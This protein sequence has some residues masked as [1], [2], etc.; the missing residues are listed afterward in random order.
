MKSS[1]FHHFERLLV[2]AALAAGVGYFVKS[3]Q[4][5]DP[6]VAVAVNPGA[7]EKVAGRDPAKPKA[8][9]KKP[10]SKKAQAKPSRERT[11]SREGDLDDGVPWL[12][13]AEMPTPTPKHEDSLAK[14]PEPDVAKAP[15]VQM[16]EQA[17]D[18]KFISIHRAMHRNPK[19]PQPLTDDIKA[20]LDAID[21]P[22]AIRSTSTWANFARHASHHQLVCMVLDGIQSSKST[23]Y[24]A[25][26][27]VY[28]PDETTRDSAAKALIGRK[29]YDFGIP[30]IQLIN[31]P[32]VPRREVI[33]DPVQGR[34]EVLL[35]EGQT[36]DRKFLYPMPSS[37]ASPDCGWNVYTADSP[38]MTNAQKRAWNE[39]NRQQQE[40]ARGMVRLQIE[41]DLDQVKR[42]NIQIAEN[43]ARALKTLS[44]AT[45]RFYRTRDQWSSWLASVTG[46]KYT[47]PQDAPRPTLTQVVEPL[48]QP[49]FV[50]VPRLT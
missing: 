16:S 46:R 50:N 33:D 43:K 8:P 26:L 14:S 13:Q 40:F 21:D 44:I 29:P 5:P 31:G 2:V 39:Y 34:V 11:Q 22:N 48:Y 3:W 10:A 6:P 1:S 12:E 36:V 25:A 7:E 20:E 35:V 28:S 37:P 38:Y 47:P 4:A 17:W 15:S 49:T 45:N 23:E 19:K 42:I 18:K 32:L 41:S 27:S 30:L 24:L 9:R